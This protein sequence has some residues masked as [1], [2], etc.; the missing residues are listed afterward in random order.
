MKDINL[1]RC[2]GSFFFKP[3]SSKSEI[4]KDENCDGYFIRSSESEA[5][6]IIDSLKNS[7]KVI[8]FEGGDSVKNRRALESLKIDYL[9]SPEKNS[10][11]HSLKQRDSGFNHVLANIAA[12][13]KIPIVINMAEVSSLEKFLLAKRISQLIQ[14]VLVCRKTGCALKIAS[15]ASKKSNVLNPH[16]RRSFGLSI[17]MSTK[18]AKEAVEF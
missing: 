6:R 17:G 11:K 2:E 12:K 13:K 8:A 5:R 7:G 3:I 14:N 1:F 15:F 9:V 10:H 4:V 18:Q 16:A